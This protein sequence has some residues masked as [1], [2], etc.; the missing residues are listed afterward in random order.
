MPCADQL[1][2]ISEGLDLD[3]LRAVLGRVYKRLNRNKV[4]RAF[5][6]H[7]L[8]VVDGHEINASYKRLCPHCQTRR[9]TVNGKKRIQYYHRAVILQLPNPRRKAAVCPPTAVWLQNGMRI[10]PPTPASLR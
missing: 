1:A 7:R 6:G 10:S 5:H 3:G 9:I 4:L 2:N 8:A